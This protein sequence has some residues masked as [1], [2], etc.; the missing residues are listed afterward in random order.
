MLPLHYFVSMDINLLP[1]PKPYSN[2][3]LRMATSF[4]SQNLSTVVV[5][6]DF[7]SQLLSITVPNSP[8]STDLQAGSY[9][10]RYNGVDVGEANAILMKV[11]VYKFLPIYEL[12]HES[13]F[14][15]VIG[16]RDS[17]DDEW[18]MISHFRWLYVGDGFRPANAGIDYSIETSD[19]GLKRLLTLLPADF[20]FTVYIYYKEGVVYIGL[21]DIEETEGKVNLSLSAYFQRMTIAF[22][23]EF[24]R[25]LLYSL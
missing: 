10:F 16:T 3:E 2:E 21:Q 5:P 17:V 7:M 22:G 15:F 18:S 20:I 9:T 25:R 6:Y 12:R 19:D 24:Q 23:D 13:D 11:G 8:W 1:K 4:L 14:K